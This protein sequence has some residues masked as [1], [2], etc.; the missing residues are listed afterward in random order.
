[1]TITISRS[2]DSSSQTRITP[3]ETSTAPS[4]EASRQNDPVDKTEIRACHGE[5]HEAVEDRNFELANIIKGNC[6]FL[7]A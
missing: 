3:A 7:E 2:T 1:M 4:G 6:A 5:L